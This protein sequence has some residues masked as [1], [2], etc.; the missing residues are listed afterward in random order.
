MK[1]ETIRN[2]IIFPLINLTNLRKNKSFYKESFLV[3]IYQA[4]NI[5]GLLFQLKIFSDILGINNFGK[6]NVFNSLSVLSLTCFS[7]SVAWAFSRLYLIAKKEN[8]QIKMINSIIQIMSIIVIINIFFSL[9][10]IYTFRYYEGKYILIFLVFLFTSLKSF[11]EIFRQIFNIERKRG[12]VILLDFFYYIVVF[13]LIFSYQKG[14]NIGLINIIIFQLI[15]LFSSIIYIISSLKIKLVKIINFLKIN[16]KKIYFTEIKSIFNLYLPVSILSL[17]AWIQSSATK[18]VLNNQLLYED[19]GKLSILQQVYFGPTILLISTL[20]SV[21]YPIINSKLDIDISGKLGI[22]DRIYIRKYFFLTSIFFTLMFGFLIILYK[23][24]NLDI[25]NF[26]NLNLTK[27]NNLLI[28]LILISAFFQAGIQVLAAFSMSI[29]KISF[30]AKKVAPF[31][32]IFGLPLIYF[33]TSNYGI[34]GALI[35]KLTITFIIFILN[36]LNLFK[37]I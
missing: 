29:L 8:N 21:C 7:N 18:L 2:N 13:L 34:E 24:F 28:N 15:G 16:I 33:L 4:Q 17:S 19:I 26:F 27:Q 5:I 12:K 20:V 11:Q 32:I 36:W 35:S 37:Y 14:T 31:I 23:I 30:F 22:K 3:L 6:L 10:G 25:L 9:I 1:R